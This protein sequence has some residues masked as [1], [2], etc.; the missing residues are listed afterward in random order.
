MGK[1]E[2]TSTRPSRPRSQIFRE[3]CLDLGSLFTSRSPPSRWLPHV[4]ATGYGPRIPGMMRTLGGG[5]NHQD[6][7]NCPCSIGFSFAEFVVPTSLTS[8]WVSSN[9]AQRNRT[10]VNLSFRVSSSTSS[11][12]NAF[13]AVV[14][15][16]HRST[17]KGSPYFFFFF[18]PIYFASC[19]QGNSSPLNRHGEGEGF[20]HLTAAISS[21]VFHPFLPQILPS[22]AATPPYLSTVLFTSCR[23]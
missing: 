15:L 23:W 11:K 16:N 1:A 19:K 13:S 14:C 18:K 2:S 12:G 6:S 20:L 22:D 4:P 21:F 17:R 9:L 3:R 10:G 8:R 5:L 7:R